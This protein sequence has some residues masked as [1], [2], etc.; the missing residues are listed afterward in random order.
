MGDA[1]GRGRAGPAG[2]P[3]V[4][5]GPGG[6][7]GSPPAG[8]AAAGGAGGGGGGFLHLDRWPPLR[9]VAVVRAGA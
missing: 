6:P 9:G 1:A 3:D 2:A 4:G 8:R 7:A 5:R